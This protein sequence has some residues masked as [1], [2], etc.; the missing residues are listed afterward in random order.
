MIFLRS[1]R[2][3]DD[4]M[5]TRDQ[6]RLGLMFEL[7]E[8]DKPVA[9]HEMLYNHIAD[10]T[11]SRA[12]QGDGFKLGL[13]LAQSCLQLHSSPWLHKESRTQ[14]IL[15]FLKEEQSSLQIPIPGWFFNGEDARTG[16]RQATE[17]ILSTDSDLCVI[18]IPRNWGVPDM[19]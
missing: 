15:F 14:N 17:S 19:K 18:I 2:F 3:L 16:A 4:P 11:F 9:R 10:R 5:S 6:A 1:F 12:D 7:S 8:S 13:Q